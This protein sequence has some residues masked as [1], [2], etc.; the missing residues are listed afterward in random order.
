MRGDQ[1]RGGEDE[2]WGKDKRNKRR[3]GEERLEEEGW[4]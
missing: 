3:E 2:K 4:G 1:R